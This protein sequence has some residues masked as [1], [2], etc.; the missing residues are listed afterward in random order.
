MKY[1]HVALTTILSVL[2]IFCRADNYPRN[3]SI[4]VLHYLFELKLS[5]NTDEILGKAS[6]AVLFKTN[7][8]KQIR[9]DLI[10]TNGKYLQKGMV[11]ESVSYNNTKAIFSHKNDALIIQLSGRVAKDSTLTFI[12]QYHGVP[13]GGL[14]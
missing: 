4:D 3:Y 14:K 10:N 2:A 7:D 1:K 13:A 12:I 6:I 8:V 9:L 11:V 5:D